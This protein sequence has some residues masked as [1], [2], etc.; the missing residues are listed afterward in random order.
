[1][2]KRWLKQFLAIISLSFTALFLASCSSQQADDTEL[3]ATAS[4]AEEPANTSDDEVLG[5][6]NSSDDGL[7]ENTKNQAISQTASDGQAHL[8]QDQSA[9]KP[10]NVAKEAK[11]AETIVG[12]EEKQSLMAEKINTE[13]GG[14]IGGAAGTMAAPGL[15]E[16]GSKLSYIVKEGDTLAKISKM[17]FG[18]SKR[19]RHLA[20]WTML[21]N[22][23]KIYPGE[24][25]YYQLE[26]K[27]LQFAKIYENLPKKEAIVNQG[28]TLADVAK[29]L[30]G[31]AKQWKYLWRL[32]DKV[33]APD[34]LTAGM[35]ISYVVKD[36]L[37]MLDF[38]FGEQREGNKWTKTGQEYDRNTVYLTQ[39]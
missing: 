20:K 18:S 25:I 14:L 36:A 29:R 26:A 8:A 38:E 4:N 27:S 31:S 23:N 35:K 5:E 37:A 32:N 17:I 34:Q 10:S 30:Y 1:M 11:P 39:Q 16:M 12:A 6:S 21:A 33:V 22:P 9:D 19:W 28:E 3:E 15:P 13:G 2:K 24:V 7:A